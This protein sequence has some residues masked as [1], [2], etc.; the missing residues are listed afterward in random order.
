MR[1]VVGFT[2]RSNRVHWSKLAFLATVTLTICSC[3][4]VSGGRSTS[5][6]GAPE[7]GSD[8][9]PTAPEIAAQPRIV[10]PN[11]YLESAPRISSATTESFN[12]GISQMQAENWNEAELIFQE[13]TLT[14]PSL[15]GPWV[16]LGVIHYNREDW[17]NAKSAWQKAIEINPLNFDAYNHLAIFNREQGD[18]SA[19]EKNY[20]NSLA[21][22][23]DN[24]QAHCNL[25]ILYDLYMGLWDRA[26][27]EYKECAA[28]TA[29]PSRQLKGWIVDMERRINA[30]NK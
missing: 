13:L 6:T 14:E 28:L 15:S 1:S 18:F 10:T 8:T 11:P 17:N 2:R 5:G 9:E 29:E 23:P 22:W 21:K 16:N 26:L 3:A 19:A 24:A 25:G 4:L 20:L 30:K 7:D 12:R 27:A